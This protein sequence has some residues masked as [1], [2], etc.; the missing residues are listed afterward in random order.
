MTSLRSQMPVRDATRGTMEIHAST[1]VELRERIAAGMRWTLWLSLLALPF[2]YGTNILLARVGPDALGT[3]G[4]LNIYIGLV[5]VFFFFGGCAVPMKFLPGLIDKQR[6]AFLGTYSLVL[7]LT[8]A[9]WLLFATWKPQLLRFLF[10]SADDYT[11]Q[12]RLLYLSPVCVACV[13]IITSLKGI[14]EIQ[15]A[16]A[17]DR[18]S[19]LGLLVALLTAELYNRQWL[20]QHAADVVW[21][22]Y[23]GLSFLAACIGFCRLVAIGSL[24]GLPRLWLPPGF[25]RYTLLLQLSSVLSFLNSKLDYVFVLNAGGLPVLGK[26]VAITSIA[27]IIPRISGFIIDSLL[28]SITNCLATEDLQSAKHVSD[29]YLRL[30][31]PVVLGL[32]FAALG[33]VHAFLRAMGLEYVELSALVQFACLIA[34]VQ[35]LNF[36]A[37]ALFAATDH[38]HHDVAGRLART[39]VFACLFWPFFLRSE[40]V[41][42]VAAWGAGEI[43][44]LVA[45]LY[46]LRRNRRLKVQVL[47]EGGA[48]LSALLLAV[49]PARYVLRGDYLAGTLSLS[50]LLVFFFFMARYSVSEVRRLACLLVTGR[51][52]NA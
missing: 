7:L 5:Y 32:S 4:V 51:P 26:Y 29:T 20:R 8:L 3:F 22:T 42:A 10:G 40:L 19:T 15:W 37:S 14:L 12:L 33:C 47:R 48:F 50:L 27:G 35:A 28:P 23:I 11:F 30:F 52:L 2:S 46:F 31:F 18:I 44:Y 24:S 16:Q 6:T 21:T 41:G 39:T 9:P 25:W 38:I 49:I 45:S 17:L 43:A 36:Y 1:S 34:A 13:L